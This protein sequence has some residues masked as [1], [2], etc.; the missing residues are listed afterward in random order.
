MI[1]VWSEKIIIPTLLIA[2]LYVM[3]TVYLMNTGLVKDTIFGAHSISYKWNLLIALLAGMWTVMSKLSLMLLIIVAI[4]TGANLTLVV[5][6][7]QAIR[8]SGKMSF[9]VGGSSLLGIVGS[10]CASCGLPI[11]AF[12]GISGAIFYLPFQG[13]ELSVLAI[14]LLSVSLYSLIKQRTKQTVCAV[15]YLAH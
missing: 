7:L 5:Q 10:G 9:M 14:V 1:K 2:A 8:A 11:L 3:V 6:R 4:L 12:L 15:D 13:L